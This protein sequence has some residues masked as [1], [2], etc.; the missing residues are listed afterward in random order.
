MKVI[1]NNKLN[2]TLILVRE[3][4]KNLN[5]TSLQLTVFLLNSLSKSSLVIFS[6]KSLALHTVDSSK[7]PC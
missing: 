7:K 5:V 3:N 1:I 4:P 6:V 2:T